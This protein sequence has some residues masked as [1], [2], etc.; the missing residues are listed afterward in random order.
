MHCVVN[1]LK[2]ECSHGSEVNLMQHSYAMQTAI[3]FDR[4]EIT[5]IVS[6]CIVWNH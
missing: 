4:A 5:F 1:R 3:H 6:L 2:H